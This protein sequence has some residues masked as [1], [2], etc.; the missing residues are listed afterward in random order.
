M[1]VN[2]D[3]SCLTCICGKNF[4]V[5]MGYG[6]IIRNEKI[7]IVIQMSLVDGIQTN[8]YISDVSYVP[9]LTTNL[10]SVSCIW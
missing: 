8:I 1:H 3:L 6:S 5:E 9:K 4:S 2:Q 7:G 10:L